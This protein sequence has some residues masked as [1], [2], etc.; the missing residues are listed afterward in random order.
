MGAY[1][2]STWSSQPPVPPLLAS[3][4]VENAAFRPSISRLTCIALLIRQACVGYRL[5]VAYRALEYIVP[6]TVN[7]GELTSA[8]AA[9]TI[10]VEPSAAASTRE[11]KL[12]AIAGLTG[13][14]DQSKKI[15]KAIK[16]INKSRDKE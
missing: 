3:P 13:Y 14:Q 7:D 9:A 12:Q 6:L 4:D 11:L 16:E 5:R 15:A 2:S 10:T 8:P 1:V